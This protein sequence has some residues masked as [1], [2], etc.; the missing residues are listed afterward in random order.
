MTLGPDG[1]FYGT[2]AFGG[3]YSNGTVFQMTT[4]GT[5]TTLVNFNG[6]NGANPQASLAVGPGGSIYG[7]T[8]YGGTN[9]N[10]GTVFAVTT[11]G[12][13]T[14]LL[15]FGGTNGAWPRD[16]VTVGPDGHLYGTTS[17]GGNPSGDLSGG[18]IFE[19][20]TNGLLTA[21]VRLADLSNT[22]G[23]R[24]YAGLTL[25]PDG[26]FYGTTTEGGTNNNGTVFQVTTNGTLALLARIPGIQFQISTNPQ[27]YEYVAYTTNN[28][29]NS[30]STKVSNGTLTTLYSF[31]TLTNSINA[32]GVGAQA[33]LTL[34][35]DG[36]FY[37]TAYGGG[38]NGYGTVFKVTTNG[39]FTTL[40]SFSGNT[41]VSPQAALM[42]GPGG[43]LYGT[44][45]SGGTSGYGTVFKITDG[46]ALTTVVN[47]DRA[48]DGANPQ[49]GLIP[50]PGGNFYGTASGGG[51]NLLYLGNNAYNAVSDGT[52]FEL[53][54]NGIFSCWHISTAP[55]GPIP[56][57]ELALGL[58]GNLYGTTTYGG[59]S[60]DGTIFQ[61]KTNGTFTGL[62]SFTGTNGATRC[63]FDVG[64]G[65]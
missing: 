9:G 33:G 34:G 15:Q 49:A 60:N 48:N 29:T 30:A 61:V 8:E 52:V 19:L 10:F 27:G 50:G 41:G 54:T 4:N 63:R 2:T 43:S 21:L 12:A 5:L 46:G 57:G 65:R 58:D 22:N 31:S 40:V 42:Q 20:T 47:F 44:T 51:T 3:L 45:Q 24:P 17:F 14:T 36:N 38:A 64:P 6:T 28:W 55:T 16:A 23:A 11:D 25:G 26:N 62:A 7:T 59:I 37:G 56:P 35:P 53:T 39:T 18:S 32:D 13:F 1:N